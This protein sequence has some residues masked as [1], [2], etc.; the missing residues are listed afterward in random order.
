[1]GPDGG[2][3]RII[4]GSEVT[5]TD[6]AMPM[7]NSDDIGANIRVNDV[8]ETPIPTQ[9]LSIA[10]DA[11][12]TDYAENQ[13]DTTVDTYTVS[14]DNAA[15]ATWS[16]GG[17]DRALFDLDEDGREAT[18]SFKAAP[19]FEMKADAD[20]NN[21]YMVTIQARH[22]ADDTT[23][24]DVAIT[25]TN[26]EEDGTVTL[27]PSR[28]SV[29]TEITATVED[30]DIV[31]S[32]SWQWASADAMDGTFTNISGATS[33]T[34]TP[35][36]DDEGDYLRATATYTD[37]F[38]SRNVEMAVSESA[39]LQVPVN[40]APAFADATATRTIAENTAAGTAIGD[41][42]AATDPNGDTVTYTLEGTD[43]ASFGI[44]RSTGQLRT[45]AALNYET[46]TTYNVVV[47]ASDP[48]GLSATIT[49]TITVTDVVETPSTTVQDY[50][51]NDT[52][53]IQIDELFAAIDDYFEGQINIDE[54]FEVIDAYFE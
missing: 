50:D 46:K 14:G 31:S 27:N 32:E 3:H 2:Q 19:D 30:D 42:V 45:S 36:A 16:L 40:V 29:G 13:E 34:Y 23:T 28:P 38:D 6:S 7:G 33:A 37:G 11:T 5:A 43:A 54:L 12:V 22:D 24:M 26:V 48:A 44:D 35:V 49:V 53:G 25:V 18:L 41:P 20:A 21:V 10:G 39:V 8:N 51:T 4:T 9:D 17:A 15:T 1:M 47:R 52:A